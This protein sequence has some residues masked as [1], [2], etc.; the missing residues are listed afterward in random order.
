MKKK[1]HSLFFTLLHSWY[2]D[3]SLKEG[4]A[5]SFYTVLSLP[6]LI[7]ATTSVATLFL[8][9]QTVQEKILYYSSLSFGENG[10]NIISTLVTHVPTVRSLTI[11]SVLS[12]I[13]LLIMASSIFSSLQDA[14]NIIWKTASDNCNVKKIIKNRFFLFLPVISLGLIL[15][16]STFIQSLLFLGAAHLTE[17][18]AF[19]FDTIALL[20][21]I[22]NFVLFTSIL[23]F[24]FRYLP[25]SKPTW[26]AVWLGSLFSAVLFTVGKYILGLY[27]QTVQVGSAYGAAGSLLALLVW[28]Y[29]SSQTV[30]LGAELSKHIDKNT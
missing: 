14:L 15:V 17:L 9:E 16:F 21:G 28:V 19:P 6:A 27:I 22:T 29:Y 8:N 2:Q 11:T 26:K 7:L 23:A 4:A 10:Q 24:L 20:S 18:I 12:I 25:D 13:F 5:L 30:F 1:H 3:G